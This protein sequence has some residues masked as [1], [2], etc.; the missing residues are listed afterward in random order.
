MVEFQAF[1][2]IARLSRDIVVTEK[3]DG[4]NAAIR[5]VTTTDD[6]APEI[7]DSNF[8]TV[9][10]EGV[11]AHWIYA[12]SRSRFI[13]L[14][15]DNFGFARWVY[16]NAEEL[17]ALGDGIHYGEWWGS[18]IQRGYGLPKGQ[19]KFSLFNVSRWAPPMPHY[20]GEPIYAGATIAPTFCDVVPVLYSGTFS[21]AEI[22]GAL[23][24]LRVLG[25]RATPFMNPEGIMIYHT[26]AS[27]YFKKTFE[28]DSAG[29]DLSNA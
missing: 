3:L 20:E 17:V 16:D 1:P 29:K 21:E 10:Y 12:Q 25:S 2:K 11:I 22:N 8:T 19:K 4:T 9:V 26:A 13:T 15:Q 23:T 18:G 28:G 7:P 5:I 6:K 27:T 24:T 14:G